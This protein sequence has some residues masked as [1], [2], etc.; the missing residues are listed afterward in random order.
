MKHEAR[1]YRKKEGL[2]ICGLC[3][4]ACRLT[5]GETG[6][7]RTRTNKQGVLITT[8]Y[9]N[10]CALHIDPVEKKPLNHFLPSTKTLSLSTAGCNLA[11]LNCQN[12]SISQV[13]PNE[14]RNTV[15]YPDEVVKMAI[16]NACDSISY[17]YTDPV[18]Y[19]EY[20]LDTARLAKEKGL[21]NIMVSA[22]YINPQPLIELSNYLDAANIDLKCFDD[23]VYQ[24]LCG[25]RLTPVLNTLLTLKQAGVWLEITNL[26][27]PGYSDDLQVIDKMFDWLIDN[28]FCH[29]PIH[30]NRFVP[31][32]QLM[33]V[34]A[35]RSEVLMTI[36]DLAAQK[37]LRYI[38]VGNIGHN[39]FSDTICPH[40]L[41]TQ[42][43]RHGY[44]IRNDLQMDGHCSKCDK[45]IH[46]VW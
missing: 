26:I 34:D 35:T 43:S 10:P 28:D 38:Y 29:V 8:A 31:T 24:Q 7:C 23:E 16:D 36:A 33:H 42:I 41:E 39:S 45:K 19:Y 32:H 9:G 22:G 20:M 11:C 5:D 27:V 14:I 12:H 25:I 18:V 46:G 37:G 44:S 17:T 2:I 6:L 30:I 40:C 1:Y 13:S 4:H 21:K 15:L 3:P